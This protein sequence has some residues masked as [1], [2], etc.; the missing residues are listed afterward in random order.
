MGLLI[1]M[2]QPHDMVLPT[3]VRAKDSE[4]TQTLPILPFQGGG[5]MMLD[6]GLTGNYS[7]S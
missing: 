4:N 7:S 1:R 6:V 5:R 3:V 2:C